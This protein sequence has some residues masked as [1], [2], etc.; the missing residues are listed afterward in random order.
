MPFRVLVAPASSAEVRP[1]TMMPP[2]KRANRT[3]V[4]LMSE[5]CRTRKD[6]TNRVL[7]MSGMVKRFAIAS[8]KKALRTV[9]PSWLGS[10]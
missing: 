9:E 3:E 5:G 6:N 1:P 4:G 8:R 2:N 10:G 7:V